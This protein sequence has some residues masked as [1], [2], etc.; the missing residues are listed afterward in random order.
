MTGWL[1]VDPMSDKY[2]GISSY[3]YCD[4]NPIKY[5][6]LD[7]EEK[8]IFFN[9]Q[10]PVYSSYRGEGVFGQYMKAIGQYVSNVNLKNSANR[11]KD[12]SD[13]IHLFAHGNST[14]I[15]LAE[16]GRK[17]AEGLEFF[18]LNN[19]EVYREGLNKGE[20]S[21][22]IMHSCKTGSGRNSIAQQ[23]SKNTE[24]NLLV[25][26]PSE[27]VIMGKDENV[28][29]DGIWNVFYKGELVGSYK[30]TTDFRK[31]LEGKNAQTIIK[32]W[33]EKYKRE[34]AND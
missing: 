10:M 14:S 4:W 5:V 30:G 11:Y 23:L 16:K 32:R 8:L 26:A 29:N 18:L 2:P 34:H 3:A 25:I 31:E 15:N 27:N 1:S 28:K 19:S 24:G 22:L 20:V 9:T 13:V 7:G 17:H 21:L 33:T 6:D 12:H